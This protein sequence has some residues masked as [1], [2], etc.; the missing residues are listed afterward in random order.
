MVDEDCLASIVWMDEAVTAFTVEPTLDDSCSLAQFF[1][2]ILPSSLR[3]LRARA[4]YTHISLLYA[5]ASV[6][7]QLL[8]LSVAS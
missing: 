4:L 1:Q 2:I 8:M 7:T 5:D 3:W 6:D